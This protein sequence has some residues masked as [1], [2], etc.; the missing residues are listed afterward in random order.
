MSAFVPL[1]AITSGAAPFVLVLKAFFDDSGTHV[2][3]PVTVMGGL[4][5]HEDEWAALEPEWATVRDDLGIR[6]MHMS[7]CEAP[8]KEFRGWS[9]DRRDI[10][11][12]RFRSVLIKR[13]ALMLVSAV[14][15][16]SWDAAA[17]KSILTELF[18][19]PLDW[20]FN[21]CMQRALRWGRKSGP[22]S[23]VVTFDCREESLRTWRPRAEGYER[24]YPRKVAGFAFS[25]MEKVLPLQAAD[26][27]AYEGFV[28]QCE[29]ERLRAEPTPRPNFALLLEK[30]QFKGGFYTEAQLLAYVATVE[31]GAAAARAA[32]DARA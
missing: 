19:T 20:C 2:G 25:S 10:A 8:Y 17:S 30:L 18:P 22:E 15:Q 3:S 13:D 4:I 7:A 12:N 27:V 6:M 26:M 9:R 29:R 31:A 24:L 5:A 21:D 14:S 23:V 28:F 32:R 1:R 16:A 11:I